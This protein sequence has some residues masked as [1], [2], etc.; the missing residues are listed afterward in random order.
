M[1]VDVPDEVGG[2]SRVDGVQEER[3]LL[4]AFVEGGGDPAQVARQ[5]LQADTDTVSGGGGHGKPNPEQ[6]A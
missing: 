4:A 6:W 3:D 5:K 2:G 1:V